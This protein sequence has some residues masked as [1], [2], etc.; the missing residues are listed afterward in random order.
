MDYNS[1]VK[2]G[3]ERMEKAV[4]VL[5]NQFRG[6]RTGRANAG[7][8]EDVRVD[9]YGSPTPLKQIAAI[10]APEA[11]LIVIKPFDPSS[12]GAVQKALQKADLGIQPTS[13]GKVVRLVIPPLSED[14]RKQL[15]AHA[16]QMAEEARV[17]ARN[18]RRDCNRKTEQIEKDAVVSEDQAESLRKEI[19]NLTDKCTKKID[20]L[21]EK[22]SAELM[23]F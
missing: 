13:D 4:E 15:V 11:N 14:R 1:V 23:E 16:K 20:E 9:Y 2:E 7:L 17:A 5:Q 8:V 6:M 19:Q 22:K 21:F 12:L 10:S 18:V 3:K